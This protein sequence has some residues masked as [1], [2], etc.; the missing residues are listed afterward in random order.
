[1]HIP[2][3]GNGDVTS[4][5]IAKQK[6]DTYGVDA[7]MI[8]RAAIGKPWLF[9]EV[10]H[11]LQT[12]ELLPAITVLEKVE[13]AKRHLQYSLDW[14]GPVVGVFEMRQH[15]SNYFKALPDF[16]S[17]RIRLVTESNPEIL[18][19]ILNEIAEKWGEK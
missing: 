10:K 17:T 19:Q 12:G 14:K 7:I 8:G 2:I 3:I 16:K 9:K 15:F 18:V 6:F 5:E 13:L 11:Y 1:M 4:P